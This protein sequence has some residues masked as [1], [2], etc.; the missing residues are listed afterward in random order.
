[1]ALP[2]ETKAERR[3]R[4][5]TLLDNPHVK[6]QLDLIAASEGVQHG[7]NTLFGNERFDSLDEHPNISKK[8]KQTNNRT[9]STTAAGRY[10]F[11]KSTWDEAANALGL[12]DFSPES[13]DLAAIYL[14]ERARA[15]NDVASGDFANAE[16][17]LGKVWASLPS[18][19]YPQPTRSQQ[20]VRDFL[21]ERGYAAPGGDD[22]IR[23]LVPPRP[24]TLEA[25]Q[26]SLE[27]YANEVASP[28][29]NWEDDLA[30]ALQAYQ[31]QPR[32][33]EDVHHT[34]A[35]RLP[36]GTA[37]SAMDYYD[38]P[39]EVLDS[40]PPVDLGAPSAALD[41]PPDALQQVASLVEP[42]SSFQALQDSG[43]SWQDQLLAQAMQDEDAQNRRQAVSAFFGE[44]PTPD[45]PFPKVFDEYI[46]RMLETA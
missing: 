3:D 31:D 15:L 14:M 20:F 39:Q 43:P 9:R 32:Q 10:Q 26:N 12:A 5:R 27:R 38:V 33:G 25:V 2:P 23:A 24:L 1:M 4:Y 8:F 30:Q 11:L 18:S 21:A 16:R 22:V 17:K 44:Q 46:N 37:K 34:P 13:Q 7:Y 29:R 45:I 35:D 36:D 40:Y 19:P 42:Q 28:E 6:T 41:A